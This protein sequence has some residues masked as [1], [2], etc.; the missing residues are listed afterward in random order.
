MPNIIPLEALQI[1]RPCRADWNAM[2]GDERARH[3]GSCAKTVYDISQMT[4]DEAHQLIA[5]NEGHVCVRLYKRADGTVITSDCPVGKREAMRPMWWILAGFAALMASGA[6]VWSQPTAEQP[7]SPREATPLIDKAREWPL[8]GAVVNTVSPTHSMIMGDIAV[9][10]A[11]PPVAPPTMGLTAPVPTTSPTIA[12][13]AQP[14]MGRVAAPKLPPTAEPV[15]EMGE[16]APVCPP[17]KP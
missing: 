1:A 5:A 13:T 15:F 9:M 2:T 8:V 17:T 14:L 11:A 16:I 3:C 10:P 12:P 7:T 6:V 4:R